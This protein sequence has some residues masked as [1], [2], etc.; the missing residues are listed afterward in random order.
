MKRLD[1]L[2]AKITTPEVASALCAGWQM[3]GLKVVFTN[4]VF[5]I[6]HHGHVALLA[7]AADCGQKLIVAVNADVSVRKL[8][9]GENRPVNAESDR[10]LVIAA[11]QMVDLVII[12]GEDTPYELI[13]AI[14]PDVI[15]KG[16][17]YDP[18][19]RDKNAKNYLVG[20][21]LQRQRGK[22]TVVVPIVEGYSTT[23]IIERSKSGKG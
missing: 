2:F 17:D 18:D 22:E 21:D 9:K 12:F 23:S 14:A 7:Q 5:D 19:Q 20:S 6:V 3:R 4:G 16:G 10:A 13:K 11:M 1:P 8:G 15:V